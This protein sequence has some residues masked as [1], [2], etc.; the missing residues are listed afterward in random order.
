MQGLAEQARSVI[1]GRGSIIDEYCFDTS[2]SVAGASVIDDVAA[3]ENRVFGDLKQPE[4]PH[5][6]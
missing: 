5:D 6:S 1:S 3:P 2:A 4:V